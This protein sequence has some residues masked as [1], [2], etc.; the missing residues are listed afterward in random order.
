M[1]ETVSFK[2][3]QEENFKE[4]HLKADNIIQYFIYGYFLFGI[5]ISFHYQT[6]LF[7]FGVGTA[8]LVI[9][10][11][12]R[13]LMPGTYAARLVTSGVMGVYMLQ[14]VSQMHGMYEMHFWYFVML[15]VLIIYQDWRIMVP[16]TLITV[17]QHIVL[18]YFQLSGYEVKEYF[19]NVDSLSVMVMLYHNGIAVVG[20]FICGW[21]AIRL[22]NNSMNEFKMR[23][24]LN[25][26][27]DNIKRFGV[28][29]SQIS[30]LINENSNNLQNIANQV[31]TGASQ[32]AAST[33]E[34]SSTLEQISA[35]IDQNKN[36]AEHTKDLA[37]NASEGIKSSRVS[38]EGSV[39]SM[40]EITS[41]IS[42]INDIAFQT[43][44]LALNAAVEAARAG[45]SGKGFAV[46]AAEV[47]KLAERSKLAAVD[48]D[49]L[50]KKSVTAVI[51]TKEML[52]KLEPIIENTSKKVQE[53][54]A[55][56][57]EQ[58]TGT[59]QINDAMQQL[60]LVTQ[61]NA[62]TSEIMNRNSTEL[63]KLSNELVENIEIIS[64][65]NSKPQIADT[66]Q[67]EKIAVNDEHF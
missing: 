26:N 17:G 44:L 45:D 18:F 12:S 66:K 40:E 55:A 24:Q 30:T 6:W 21:W 23:L 62:S 57:F 3:R 37:I 14:F 31:S 29:I 52:E 32:Q 7:G 27:I 47:R 28:A 4:L 22:K 67:I 9:Y 20:T 49:E 48:I 13:Y 5:G 53:I 46:V 56:S 19:I 1:A 15:T 43:N 35:N 33:E 10:L 8:L 59:G 39:K 58:S 38:M 50:S 42:I 51:S 64:N 25:E 2:E 54:S 60:N 63:S 11:L 16:Y 36:N 41:K 65:G 61:Q 34:M